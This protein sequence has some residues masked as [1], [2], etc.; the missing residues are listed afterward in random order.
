MAQY[1][2]NAAFEVDPQGDVL[3]RQKGHPIL[4]RCLVTLPENFIARYDIYEGRSTELNFISIYLHIPR[5]FVDAKHPKITERTH[6]MLMDFFFFPVIESLESFLNFSWQEKNS[7]RIKNRQV[8]GG[9][10]LLKLLTR[11]Q[12]FWTHIP[13]RKY[14]Q[15]CSRWN[16]AVY[17]H[18][19]TPLGPQS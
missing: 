13:T 17:L 12:K 11:K 18:V 19:E 9:E 15:K 16:A 8:C 1:R 3:R 2:D 4:S 14:L 10:G 7:L 6:K 5:R